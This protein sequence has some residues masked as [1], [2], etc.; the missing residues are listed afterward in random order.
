MSD[1]P[2]AADARGSEAAE[3][4]PAVVAITERWPELV[5]AGFLMLLAVIDIVDSLRIGAGWADDGPRA[6]YFPFYIGL[7]L[8]G[9]SGW[10]FF[11]TL[12]RWRQL[13]GSFVS[14]EELRGVLAVLWPS[15][16]YVAVMPILGLYVASVLLIGFFMRHH[17]R[18]GW[19]ISI[20]VSVGVPV[21]FYLVF[22][23]WFL[24]PL[25]KGPLE[26]AIG[27]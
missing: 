27:L 10:I 4:A 23:R 16:A 13:G 25:P 7:I 8:L 6:G 21:V 1:G 15:A 2:E 9:A 19:P 17:G 5:V 26:A 24:V 11:R 18:Y 12:L 3:E 20:A 14:R 22:E